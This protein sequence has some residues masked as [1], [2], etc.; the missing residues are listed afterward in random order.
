MA[1]R[2][3]IPAQTQF[4]RLTTLWN[5]EIRKGKVY[6]ECQCSCGKTLWVY[7][8]HLTS[9]KTKSC[10]CLVAD[11]AKEKF[12]T[13][14]MRKTRIYKI[15]TAAKQRC[16]NPDDGAYSDYWWRWIK[17]MWNNFENFYIDMGP[18][19]NQH[20][21]E[22][23]EKDT[24][25]DRIDNNWN[26]CKEN[27]RR[28]TRKE[29]ATNR[30]SSMMC[31]YEWK[32]YKSLKVLCEELWL[33]YDVIRLRI[34]RWWGL[35]QALETPIKF[36]ETYDYNGKIYSSLRELSAALNIKYGTVRY[37]M[38]NLWRNRKRAVETPLRRNQYK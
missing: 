18:S 5:Q 1:L 7:R 11:M 6:E 38:D 2:Y 9:W 13:H 27:C 8:Y 30:R 33:K 22:Y 21:K 32:T 20:V 37:R 28:A 25:I 36:P 31:E 23:W 24:T 15:Y 35:Q 12:T 16:I 29:Q 3:T 19:Y 26:Y 4:G 14:W 10:W 34:G 17:F